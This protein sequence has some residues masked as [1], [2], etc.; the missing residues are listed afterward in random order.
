[1]LKK[2]SIGQINNKTNIYPPILHTAK[3]WLNKSPLHM[4]MP[5]KTL[6]ITNLKY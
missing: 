6:M 2:A 3:S 1:M 5:I 4:F